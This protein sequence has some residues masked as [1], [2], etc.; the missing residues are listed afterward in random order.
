MSRVSILTKAVNWFTSRKHFKGV[1]DC[2][3]SLTQICQGN[4][5]KELFYIER[6]VPNNDFITKL[7]DI[8]R[9]LNKQSCD[10]N[11]KS[12]DL[13]RNFGLFNLRGNK[14]LDC[15]LLK[16]Q[17][18]CIFEE[19]G[20]DIPL[21]MAIMAH[22]CWVLDPL[23]QCNF[24][25]EIILNQLTSGELIGTLAC[26]E[27]LSGTDFQS[28]TSKFHSDGTFSGNKCW[29]TN[30]DNA[31]IFLVSG[32]DE[33]G[34]MK[35]GLVRKSEH[36]RCKAMDVYGSCGITFGEVIFDNATVAGQLNCDNAYSMLVSMMLKCRMHITELCSGLAKSILDEIIAYLRQEP[37]IVTKRSTREHSRICEEG[38]RL[39][40]TCE[41]L[42]F[43]MC[44]VDWASDGIEVALA[45]CRSM[46]ICRKLLSMLTELLDSKIIYSE[47]S[48]LVNVSNQLELMSHFGW[49]ELV[50]RLYCGAEFIRQLSSDSTDQINKFLTEGQCIR[51]KLYHESE[52]H[53]LSAGKSVFLYDIWEYSKCPWLQCHQTETC[54]IQLKNSCLHLL[55]RDGTGV[56]DD[57]RQNQ[58]SDLIRLS[59][60]AEHSL[61][62]LSLQARMH[63]GKDQGTYNIVK[64]IGEKAF[65]YESAAATKYYIELCNSGCPQ[66]EI[67]SKI[68][69][70]MLSEGR[71]N[72]A[73]P[74]QRLF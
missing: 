28:Q 22:N 3:A 14:K 10:F 68:G 24:P 46:D 17:N 49:S 15:N 13:V 54:L 63:F 2:P 7:A 33:N 65:N 8:R 47:E 42:A 43:Y 1:T 32:Y 19:L 69:R 25:D 72:I 50:V 70:S 21:A 37:G 41:S 34:C 73:Y 60:L 51:E 58:Q 67:A 71:Y 66:S 31:E 30:I 26:N 18:A 55:L 59:Q 16:T 6:P 44:N 40:M 62:L 20:Y 45:S 57:N 29:V 12:I 56:I 64:H 27:S 5:S 48:R 61:A 36:V 9:A 35:L 74:V 39:T 38:T 4:V 53:C 11:H 52:R 23:M